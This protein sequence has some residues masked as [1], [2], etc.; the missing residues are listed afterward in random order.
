[1][2]TESAVDI[3]IV[4]DNPNDVELLLRV[5]KWYSF[6]DSICVV[7]DGE[8]AIEFIYSTG[9]YSG[10]TTGMPKM[11]LLDLKLPGMDGIEVL[12]RIKGDPAT[13]AVPVVMLT[14]SNEDRDIVESYNLGVNSYIVKPVQFYQ[15]VDSIKQLGAYWRY[16]N[17]HPGKKPETPGP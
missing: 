16:L 8:E 11:I 1:M 15:F 3:L 14:S 5:F 12:R 13:R 6:S 4:E 7:G 2:M 10:R 17:Q 9:R